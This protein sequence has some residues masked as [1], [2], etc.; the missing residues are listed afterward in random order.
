MQGGAQALAGC[1]AGHVCHPGSY[2]PVRKLFALDSGAVQT[3]ATTD[4]IAKQ[5][6]Q[7]ETTSGSLLIQAGLCNLESNIQLMSSIL[8]S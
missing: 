6:K 2:A 7:S 8:K 5:N 4:E 1:V 3:R